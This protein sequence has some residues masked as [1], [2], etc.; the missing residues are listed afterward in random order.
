M[1]GRYYYARIF[2]DTIAT[3]TINY[4]KSQESLL[5]VKIMTKWF[6]RPVKSCFAFNHST[7][8]V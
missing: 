6:S 7:A 5:N 3:R 4:V 8:N 2:T 1:C